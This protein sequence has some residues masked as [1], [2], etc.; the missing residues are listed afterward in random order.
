MAKAENDFP[1]EFVEEILTLLDLIEIEEDS[2]LAGQRFDI[3][4]K[5]GFTI[6]F[7]EPIS[8]RLH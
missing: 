7:G 5:H 6:V 4:R 2:K 3:G 1:N 8:G